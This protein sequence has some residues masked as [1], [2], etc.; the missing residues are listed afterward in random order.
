MSAQLR[1]IHGDHQINIGKFDRCYRAKVAL[2]NDGFV[3]LIDYIGPWYGWKQI[4][5]QASVATWKS[6]K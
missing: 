4:D 5:Q 2:P 6:K 1:L 3:R